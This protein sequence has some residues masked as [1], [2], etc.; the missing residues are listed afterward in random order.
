VQNGRGAMGLLGGDALV[1]AF[2]AAGALAVLWFALRRPL[3]ESRFAQVGF[4]LIAGG[5]AGNVIDRLVHGYVIDFVALPH[6]YVFNLAD[7][8]ITC[9]LCLVALPS[10]AGSNGAR[11]T[12]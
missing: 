12:S 5:A 4:G 6:F 7:A 9:G 1:L 10:V 11:V 2:L 3:A 8:A